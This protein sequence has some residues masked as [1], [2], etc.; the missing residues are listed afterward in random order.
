M[1]TS[2]DMKQPPLPLALALTL[3]L[4]IGTVLGS[5]VLAPKA[6]GPAEP[7]AATTLDPRAALESDARSEDG[8]EEQLVAA[9]PVPAIAPST[10]AAE[11]EAI[12][13]QRVEAAMSR[14]SAPDIADTSSFAGQLEVTVKRPDGAPVAGVVV[15]LTRSTDPGQSFGVHKPGMAA[16]EVLSLE[17][18][19]RKA[20]DGWATGRANTRRAVT[21][22]E[23]IARLGGL[24]ESSAYQF[25]AYLENW[26]I[27][28]PPGANFVKAGD[29]VELIA[30]PLERVQLNLVGPNGAAI[31]EALIAQE[32]GMWGGAQKWTSKQPWVLLEPGIYRL[33]AQAER[34]ELPVSWNQ[35]PYSLESDWTDVRAVEGG[36]EPTLL[37]LE[38]VGIVIVHIDRGSRSPE[39]HLRVQV[40][41]L[42]DGVDIKNFQFDYGSNSI[43]SNAN[44]ASIGSL[45][46][47]RYA[48]GLLDQRSNPI[49]RAEVQVG[50]EPVRVDLS[51]PEGTAD[52]E[53]RVSILGPDGAPIPGVKLTLTMERKD[54][55][56]SGMGLR[57]KMDLD[58][59][60]LVSPSET[61]GVSWS[62]GVTFT[63]SAFHSRFGQIQTELAEGQSEA[64]LQ[65]DEPGNLKVTV[66]GYASSG[67]AGKLQIQ[68]TPSADGHST[69]LYYH[70]HSTPRLDASGTVEFE[71]LTPGTYRISGWI[72]GEDLY[73][74]GDTVLSEEVE[75][76]SGYQE[77]VVDLPALHRVVVSAPDLEP[78]E[79]I[80][81]QL[82]DRTQGGYR[83]SMRVNLGEDRRAVFEYV[84]TGQYTVR[85][86]SGVAKV[87]DVPCGE[88]LLEA[89][90]NDALQVSLSSK[91]GGLARAGFEAGD[92]IIGIDG[93]RATSTTELYDRIREG[94]SVTLLVNRAGA[95]IDLEVDL[96]ADPLQGSEAGG[97]LVSVPGP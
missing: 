96:D 36:G 20:A 82:K 51:V 52:D 29:E 76:A 26:K 86:N 58:G 67:L 59:T 21:D 41:P 24:D 11:H 80:R 55:G 65:F 8:G 13:D 54:G 73:S 42:P 84:P 75:I 22:D 43:F 28:Q 97:Y 40:D 57:P 72:R 61:F 93:V 33:R 90:Q 25:V 60:Y 64:T 46:F 70:R 34:L 50:P 88:V 87:I 38:R 83:N 1:K 31:D 32:G 27:D 89:L 3:G 39:E 56:S 37:E 30:K 15:Q 16:P 62:A 71:A 81:M 69:R 19:L 12:S 77:R 53:L 5:V 4:A 79:T 6:T 35:R 91:T 78:G 44:T 92:Q 10:V 17:E 74:S 2:F 63:L 66:R 14:V 18:H 45:D 47:G 48:V 23:G 85:G 9:K 94:G 49:A 68:V 95:Q 7:E